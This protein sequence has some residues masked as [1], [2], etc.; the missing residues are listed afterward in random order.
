MFT[1]WLLDAVGS[2]HAFNASRFR[3]LTLKKEDFIQL[4]VAIKTEPNFFLQ[5]CS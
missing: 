1:D 5:L 2:D 4:R 3:V